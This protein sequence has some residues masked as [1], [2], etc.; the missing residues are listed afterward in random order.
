M[1]N[2]GVDIAAGNKETETRSAE[3][4]KGGR[5]VPVRL[6]EKSHFIARI[7]EDT[8]YDGCAERRMVNISVA[9]DIDKIRSVPSS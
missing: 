7:L 5:A 1:G 4:H 8:R 2:H 9:A 3:S 6:G